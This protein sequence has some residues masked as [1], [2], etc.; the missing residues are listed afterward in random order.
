MCFIDTGFLEINSVLH[1]KET[2]SSMAIIHKKCYY[3]G[4]YDI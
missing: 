3:D 2:F 1:K 4:Y